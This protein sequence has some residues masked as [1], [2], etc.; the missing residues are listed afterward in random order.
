MSMAVVIHYSR[1][2]LSWWEHNLILIL[3]SD[4]QNVF[5]ASRVIELLKLFRKTNASISHIIIEYNNTVIFYLHGKP[6][7]HRDHFNLNV[8]IEPQRFIHCNWSPSFCTH[9]V[10]YSINKSKFPSLYIPSLCTLLVIS[11]DFLVH[12]DT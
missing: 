3:E 5:I 2:I 1:N 11:H 9:T 8:H 6:H 4:I 10:S 7:F 12:S